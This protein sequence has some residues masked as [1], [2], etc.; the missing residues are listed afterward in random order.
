M[1]FEFL[2][3]WVRLYRARLLLI[4]ALS[5]LS[6]AATLAIPWL[7]A[8]FLGDLVVGN[9]GHLE[10]TLLLLALALVVLTAITITVAILSEAA[11]GRIL[12]GLR[13]EA[14]RR[15]QS[16][17]M[18]FHEAHRGGDLLALVTYEVG[19]LSSFLTAT[20]AK[21]PSMLVTAAGA[22]ALLFLLEPTLALAM[23]I[24]VPAFYI[25][26]K[27]VGRRLRSLAKRLREAEVDVVAFAEND[28]A[29]LPLIKSF[30]VEEHHIERYRAAIERAR[31]LNLAQVKASS[32]I[33]PIVALIAAGGAIAVLVYAGGD[34][35]S[36]GRTPD[37]LFAILLYAA[38]LTRPI[39]SLASTYGQFQ[40]ARGTLERL[41]RVFAME[42]EAG[43][44]EGKPVARA[45]GTITFEGVSFTYPDRSPLFESLSLTISA[46]ETVAL[47]GENGIGKSTIVKLLLRYYD[48]DAGRITLDGEDIAQLQVQDLRRQFGY[49]PQRA[50]LF[51]GTISENIAFGAP[52]V[53]AREIERAAKMAQAT[54]FIHTLP[55][56][57]N[58]VIGDDGVRLSGGQ[59]QRIALARA[60]L[61]D[62]PIYIL[63]EAT[64][65]YDLESEAA[66]IEAALRLLK[67]RT[68][69]I[70]THRP[71]SLALADRVIGPE[72][73]A[74]TRKESASETVATVSEAE[75]PR[76]SSSQA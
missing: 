51:H 23:P 57:M 2:L 58:T 61:R 3:R 44:H 18:A 75:L 56:G 34:A 60:L 42:P 72:D 71:T 65:M 15:V 30:A 24:F 46:G 6:S 69:I 28:L 20:L 8:Q 25:L 38:L 39:G 9:V 13:E 21:M 26:L 62:P 73:I 54:D 31:Y 19:T 1:R 64:S 14:Y 22:F 74:Y 76:L 52:G 33:G 67:D 48:P 70:I 16:M 59:Q 12:A 41:E 55:H 63:D 47:V 66:F 10:S 35:S 7:A 5:I 29:M 43:L 37:E 49:V 45:Q 27:L 53:G 32:F 4:S 50:M 36:G 11:S 40:I 17:P 68:V